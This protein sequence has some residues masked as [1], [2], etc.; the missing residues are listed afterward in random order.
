MNRQKWEGMVS[1]KKEYRRIFI[2][3]KR[4]RYRFG[5]NELCLHVV[6]LVTLLYTKQ[7]QNTFHD[8]VIKSTIYFDFFVFLDHIP[9]NFKRPKHQRKKKLKCWTKL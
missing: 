5:G 4:E 2:W 3:Q 9:N 7:A 8:V 1:V 6:W